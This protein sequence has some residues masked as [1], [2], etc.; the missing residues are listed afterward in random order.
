MM[1]KDTSGSMCVTS[2]VEMKEPVKTDEKKSS[3][4]S[5]F[6]ERGAIQ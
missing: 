4:L 5:K 6:V 2:E 1:I 3:L